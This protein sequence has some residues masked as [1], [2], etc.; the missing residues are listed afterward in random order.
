MNVYD[1]VIRPVL[2][3]KSYDRMPNKTYTFVVHNSANRT[4]VKIAIEQI[5]GVKV[6]K[7]NIYR[8]MGKVK[9]RGVQVGRTPELKKAIVKLFSESKDIPFFEGMV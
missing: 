5:F 4:D 9:R 7:V 2:T 8:Q 1:I 3:E 6:Q